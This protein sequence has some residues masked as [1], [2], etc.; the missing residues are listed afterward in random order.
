MYGCAG[1]VLEMLTHEGVQLT[2]ME[3]AV[4]TSS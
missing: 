1:E 2:E 4:F 3:D